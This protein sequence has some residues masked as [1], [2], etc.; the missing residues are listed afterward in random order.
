MKV[1]CAACS[2]LN[3]LPAARLLDK[4]LSDDIGAR[5]GATARAVATAS[6]QAI[7]TL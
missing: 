7:R 1:E 2:S 4:H 3:R 5:H 6:T